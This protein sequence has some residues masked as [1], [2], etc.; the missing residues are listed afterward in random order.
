[1][2]NIRAADADALPGLGVQPV[3]YFY[4]GKPYDVDS[5]SYTFKYRNYDP[6]LNRWTTVDPSGFPDGAN[7]QL[8]APSPLFE[9]DKFGL[10]STNDYVEHYFYGKA[11][12]AKG[13]TINMGT[14]GNGSAIESR[15]YASESLY[16]QDIAQAAYDASFNKLSTF[17]GVGSVVVNIDYQSDV[18]VLGNSNLRVN[19]DFSGLGS[20]DPFDNVTYNYTYVAHLQFSISDAFVDALDS[21][22]WFP[23][24]QDVPGG[25][26]YG[27]VYSW[28]SV[29]SGDGSYE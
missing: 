21:Y 9:L 16:R 23:G 27:L 2:T 25:A 15:T 28:E 18:Y 29:L 22:D 8:Y 6:E 24:N 1:M 3:E 20:I 12:Y 7:N 13:A 4:T 10:W 26:P 14:V 5:E 19:Y 11:P 17:S